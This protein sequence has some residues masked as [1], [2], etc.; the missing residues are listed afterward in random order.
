MAIEKIQCAAVRWFNSSGGATIV[1]GYQR[2]LSNAHSLIKDFLHTYNPI[3]G[4]RLYE[5]A[6]QGFYTTEGRFVD[7]KKALQ[8]AKNANQI[9]HKQPSIVNG[10]ITYNYL[11]SE[12]L[13]TCTAK[14]HG[15]C[16]TTENL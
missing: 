13:R 10:Q 5:E 1:W 9:M 15:W 2:D 7:R 6:E 16:I 14:D 3:H 11:C 12:D 4:N 8:I